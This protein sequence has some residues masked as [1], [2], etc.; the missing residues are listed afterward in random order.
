M[1]NIYSSIKWPIF[2]TW[3]IDKNHT[4]TESKI[5][6]K[7]LILW[8]KKWRLSLFTPR[9]PV[10]MKHLTMYTLQYSWTVEPYLN[11]NFN[12]SSKKPIKAVGETV[13]CH[14]GVQ[15]EWGAQQFCHPITNDLVSLFSLIFFIQKDF[16]SISTK[17]NKHPES[18]LSD[19]HVNVGNNLWCDAVNVL[20]R[21]W[22]SGPEKTTLWFEERVLESL[23]LSTTAHSLLNCRKYSNIHNKRL[24]H[25]SV[26]LIFPVYACSSVL[27]ATLM[28]PS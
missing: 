21:L 28:W 1:L 9:I 16:I 10:L 11:G 6:I 27:P 19:Q 26:T 25:V 8:G 17:W 20:K 7:M 3:F 15:F 18:D 13:H 24:F 22:F 12:N 5:V 4:S 23:F 14:S 2:A